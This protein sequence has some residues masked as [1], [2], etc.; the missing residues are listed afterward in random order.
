MSEIDHTKQ[1]IE[2]WDI[3]KIKPYEQNAK[4]HDDAQVESLS[5]SISKFGWSSPIVIWT[6]GVII[7][8]HGRRLAALKLGLKRIPV[9]VRRD[10][11]KLEA[12]A[13]RIADNQVVSKNYDTN[14][15]SDELRRINAELEI[16]GGDFELFDL[17]FTS[18]ELDILV[19][20]LEEM[21]LSVFTDDLS[22]ALAEQREKNE[23]IV[24]SID[25]TAAPVGD[26]FGFKRVTIEQS[27][28]IRNFM[29][30]IETVEG[31]KGADALLAF[32][33]K[34]ITI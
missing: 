26:A 4:I 20:P 10:L 29:R 24:A 17:G 3:D 8:G 28:E 23:A 12:D 34:Y 2:I 31:Q 19:E 11:T 5:R 27:R 6:D 25:E 9:I 21:D 1:A 30:Q 33:R 32:F 18:K 13:M 15:M 14:I 22:E 7:A 16:G